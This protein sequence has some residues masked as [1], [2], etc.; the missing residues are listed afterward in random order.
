[1]YRQEILT[2]RCPR[3]V[4]SPSDTNIPLVEVQVSGV[5][6]K[7]GIVDA[8]SLLSWLLPARDPLSFM[9]IMHGRTTLQLRPL[10]ESPPSPVVLLGHLRDKLTQLHQTHPATPKGYVHGD[11]RKTNI[12]VS[13]DVATRFLL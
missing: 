7:M 10:D 13:K 2:M 4:F 1:M 8:S 12:M 5:G 9:V 11:L 6:D 3:G